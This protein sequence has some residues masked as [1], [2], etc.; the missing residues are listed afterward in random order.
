[1][2]KLI[3]MAKKDTV[4]TISVILA[5]ISMFI[6]TPDK[7]YIKYIDFRTL[8]ILFSLMTVMQGFKNMGFFKK[9][10]QMLVSRCKSVNS[11]VLILVMMCFFGSML[12]TN[13]VALITF[14]PLTI[15]VFEMLSENT[16]SYWIIPTVVMQTIAA[17][18]GSMLT[19]VGNPQNLYLFNLSKMTLLEFIGYMLPLSLISLLLIIA[20]IVI[21]SVVF[22]W[23]NSDNSVSGLSL[24]D[25]TINLD[26]K[27]ITEYSILFVLCLLSVVRVLPYMLIF[28]I[29]AAAA[30]IS[31]RKVLAQVD[32]SLILTFT[33]LFIFIGNIGRIPAFNI[34][35]A[36]MISG[37]E[38][39]TSIISSQVMS[40]VPAAI[41]LTGFT[42]NIKMLIVGTN[43]GGLGTLIASMASLISF[44][45]IA[46]DYGH[47]KIKYIVRFT[48]YNLI[49]L[50]IL[51]LFV[52]VFKI[53]QI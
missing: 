49:F 28:V 33:A 25:E 19:P 39:Y 17:N 6:I 22:K 44:K 47:I 11:L 45:Y 13:D 53:Y 24:D 23:K 48:I 2:K 3:S 26:K 43:I 35:L 46:G 7:K 51:I 1:M 31:D 9:I 8:V 21:Q 15:T 40:N 34:F 38:L 36:K 12:I 41:L 52:N 18:L 42:D 37:R 5:V 29:V 20:V 4:L 50:L 27:R 32:Y 14:V 10:A 30:V 16:K